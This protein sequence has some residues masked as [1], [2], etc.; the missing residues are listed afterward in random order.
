MASSLEFVEG[1]RGGR[2]SQQDQTYGRQNSR[3]RYPQGS[4]G[5]YGRGGGY[6]G[7][8]QRDYRDRGQNYYDGGSGYGRDAAPFDSY[9]QEQG[10]RHGNWQTDHW[11]TDQR[12]WDR[13]GGETERWRWQDSRQDQR[14]GRGGR[15]RGKR[16]RGGRG[17]SRNPQMQTRE[18]REYQDYSQTEGGSDSHSRYPQR[19]ADSEIGQDSYGGADNTGYNERHEQQGRRGGKPRGRGR[20]RGGQRAT[21]PQTG[22]SQYNLQYGESNNRGSADGSANSRQYKH[23]EELFFTRQTSSDRE[24]V[25]S[26]E[27]NA[28][29]QGMDK[30]RGNKDRP[31]GKSDLNSGNRF[32]DAEGRS[33]SGSNASQKGERQDRRKSGGGAGRQSAQGRQVAKKYSSETQTGAL[34]EHLTSGTYECP[35]CCDRVRCE[36]RVWS[37]KTCYVVFHLGCIKKWAKSPAATAEGTDGWQCP[38]CRGVEIKIPHV[39]FCFCGKQR[40]PPWEPGETPHSCGEVCRRKRPTSCPH[41]C[42]ILC[43]PGP[44]P[45]CPSN[46][47]QKCLCGKTQQTVRCGSQ[48]EIR[49]QQPCEKLLNCGSHSCQ[50]ICHSGPCQPCEEVVVQ[51]CYCGRAKREVACTE[52]TA[53]ENPAGSYS[54]MTVCG[55]TLDC[56]HHSCE[57]F[58]HQGPCEPCGLDPARITHCPCGQTPLSLLEGGAER[59]ACTDPVPTCDKKCGKMFP[60][61]GRDTHKCEQTCHT[62]PCPPCE[63]TSMIKCRCGHRFVDVACSELQAAVKAEGGMAPPLC[64]RKCTKK[65]QCGRHKC[66]QLCCVEEEHLCLQQCGRKLKCGIHTCEEPC[67]IGNCPPCLHASFD[68]LTCHCGTE[69]M[70]PPIPCG[71]PPPECRQLCNRRHDCQ[72]PVRHHCHSDEKCPPCVELT[73]KTCIG[74]H[75]VRY[76][77]PCHVQGISCGRPCGKQLPCGYHT[78]L[79]TCHAGE[80]NP[81]CKQPCK[82]RRPDCGHPCGVTCHVGWPCPQITCKAKVK[83]S[84]PC[85]RRSQMMEC[86]ASGNDTI[87]KAMQKLTVSKLAGK[88]QTLQQN[89]DL[90]IRD[91]TGAKGSVRASRLQCDEECSI[92]ERNRRLA[93]ALQIKNPDLS[94]TIKTTNY[95]DF[96]KEQARKHQGFVAAI[97]KELSALV[98]SAKNSKQSSR[99]HAFPSMIRNHRRIIHELAEFYGCESESYDEEPKR[100]VVTTAKKGRCFMPA[101]TLT[102]VIQREL[103]PRAPLPIPH[104]SQEDEIRSAAKAIKHSTDVVGSSSSKDKVIDYFDM[105]S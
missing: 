99:S 92:Q 54:C 52:E 71:T 6:Q 69:V 7:N 85:G 86:Q 38:A 23:P 39:Y 59:T 34:I 74:G 57:D 48:K 105:T 19:P 1:D 96:L 28:T 2:M 45:P 72:H 91:M 55:R 95:S 12:D 75:E 49:C 10:Y 11:R 100:N 70:F 78:C 9:G 98:V 67:H 20:G 51:A 29:S 30:R 31:R 3:G 17:Q 87:T 32:N 80:C 83:M 88:I 64:D 53:R 101:M 97:E 63:Q 16:G 103:N 46:V 73:S 18:N 40:E 4:Y 25:G 41:P 77:I 104:H 56:G 94:S 43:H 90:D 93:E 26:A 58:C 89:E 68:E 13:A 60:C 76:N 65:K 61:G 27:S 5:G 37:C 81:E 21:H 102:A 44:C 79:K 62:G 33:R 24:S 36:A 14:G 82:V 50:E 66:G 35:V 22:T 84:C 15:G 47:Q 8:Y 42:N